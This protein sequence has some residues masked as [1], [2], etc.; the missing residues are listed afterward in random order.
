MAPRTSPKAG[1]PASKRVVARPEGTTQI[2]VNLPAGVA[3]RLEAWV[4]KLNESPEGARWTKTDII[5]TLLVRA[6]DERGEKGEAP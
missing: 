5:R 2:N 1:K 6:L 4:A 3:Q